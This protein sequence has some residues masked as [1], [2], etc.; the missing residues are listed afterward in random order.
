MAE[1]RKAGFRP[2]SAQQDR[3]S[4][5]N[6]ALKPFFQERR[7]ALRN[8]AA[9]MV[10]LTLMLTAALFG[11]AS[12][13]MWSSYWEYHESSTRGQRLHELSRNMAVADEV[14]TMS[15]RMAAATGDQQWEQRHRVYEQQLAAALDESLRIAPDESIRRAVARTRQANGQLTEI[16][17]RSLGLVRL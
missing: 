15:A 6:A 8:S 1:N 4:S 3:R 17:N 14:L 5:E 16:E 13:L 7:R 12:W 11:S 2:P 10:L 9:P